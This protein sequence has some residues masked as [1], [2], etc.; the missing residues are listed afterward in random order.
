MTPEFRRALDENPK[1]KQAY[2]CMPR[3]HQK[4][5]LRWIET[6]KRPQTRQR[7]IAES[8]RLLEQNEKLG[9]K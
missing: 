1:A 4:E 3:P 2:E 7:R 8:I 9:L 5:Y 6:T